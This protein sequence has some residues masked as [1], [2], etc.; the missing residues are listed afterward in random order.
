M[1][2]VLV[3]DGHSLYQSVWSD[4]PPGMT[5]MLAVG[6]KVFGESVWVGRGIVL[7]FSVLLLL[8]MGR[9]VALLHHEKAG[10]IAMALLAAS[11][12]FPRMSLS[13]MIGLPAMAMGVASLSLLLE[14]RMRAGPRKTGDVYLLGASAVLFAGGL[15]TK[16]FVAEMLPVVLV[17]M[18]VPIGERG[19]PGGGWRRG[20]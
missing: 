8:S 1:K 12:N 4:Q 7:G 5:W 14:W 19:R 3:S 16:F 13:A 18:L 15:L 2:A 10:W 11:F 17:A 6:F 20:C 9:I